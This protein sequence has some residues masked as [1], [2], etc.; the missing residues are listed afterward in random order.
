VEVESSIVSEASL[1][2][3]STVDPTTL[4]A[5]NKL[6]TTR[7]L[8]VFL[9]HFVLDERQVAVL[10]ARK[11]SSKKSAEMHFRYPRTKLNSAHN[12]MD[13]C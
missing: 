2:D 9:T 7:M 3:L 11:V 1:V 5:L 13:M 4:P 6:P 12:V 8:T 10:L